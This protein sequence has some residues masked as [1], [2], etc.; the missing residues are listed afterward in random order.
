MIDREKLDSAIETVRPQLQAD[1]GDVKITAID[2]ENGIVYVALQGA[3]MGCSFSSVTLSQGIERI[4]KELVPGVDRVLRDS[5]QAQQSERACIPIAEFD[6]DGN[7]IGTK[8][9]TPEEAFG[10]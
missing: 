6:D 2:D 7:F 4:V 3:C 1:G 10:E 9:V 5:S 8:M